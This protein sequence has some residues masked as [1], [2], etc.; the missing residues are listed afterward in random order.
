MTGTLNTQDY[1]NA[2]TIS[3]GDIALSGQVTATLAET[4]TWGYDSAIA[5]NSVSYCF[6]CWCCKS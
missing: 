4:F 2:L 6:W 5:A 3:L 1:P